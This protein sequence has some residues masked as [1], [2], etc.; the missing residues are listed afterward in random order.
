VRAQ[1]DN[2]MNFGVV[3]VMPFSADIRTQRSLFGFDDEAFVH[4]RR[5]LRFLLWPWQLT[6]FEA[7]ELKLGERVASYSAVCR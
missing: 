5:Y 1:P 2:I 4:S 3:S 6:Y 7:V